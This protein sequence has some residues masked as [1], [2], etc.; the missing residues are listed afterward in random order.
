MSHP[1]YNTLRNLATR[2]FEHEVGDNFH[3]SHISPFSPMNIFIASMNKESVI[4][5]MR[6]EIMGGMNFPRYP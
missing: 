2:A 4:G 1:S 3:L 5:E 6:W